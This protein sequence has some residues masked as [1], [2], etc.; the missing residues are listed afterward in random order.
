MCAVVAMAEPP[1]GGGYPNRRPQSSYLPPSHSHSH[2]HSGGGLSAG[3]GSG[4]RAVSG[5][6]QENEGQH[7]DPQLLR[8]IE[9]ILLIQ[10]NSQSSGGHGGH[11]GGHGGHGHGGK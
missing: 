6:F 2:H 1:V 3:L 11:G 9:E 7:V 4:Y 10:E 5:G 8:K